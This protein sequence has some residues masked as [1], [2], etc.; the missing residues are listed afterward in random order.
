MPG[1]ST[2]HGTSKAPCKRLSSYA[3]VAENM[4]TE[5]ASVR[6]CSPDVWFTFQIVVY[7]RDVGQASKRCTM[8][9]EQRW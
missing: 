5:Y 3:S 7:P 9:W 6:R 4:E 2:A 1:G 8:E